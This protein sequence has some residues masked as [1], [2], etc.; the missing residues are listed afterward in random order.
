MQAINWLA[1]QP[2]PADLEALRARLHEALPLR[3]LSQ[4]LVEATLRAYPWSGRAD[5]I[6]CYHPSHSY[7]QGQRLALLI[8]DPQ[9]IRHTFWLL[10]QVKDTKP[11]ENQVQGRFQVL[12]LEAH[13]R[14]IQMASGIQDASY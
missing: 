3:D 8:P 2:L 1:L 4:L 6:P 9:N 14:Q 13:G 5:L 11:V 10:A 12:T 7:Q